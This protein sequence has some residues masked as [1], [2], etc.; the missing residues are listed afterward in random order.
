MTHSS[1]KFARFMMTPIIRF[2]DSEGLN[3]SM[4]AVD[5]TKDAKFRWLCCVKVSATCHNRFLI[6]GRI[7]K[8]QI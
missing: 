3:S 8:I 7:R 1:L 2:M 6:Q 5:P 4:N